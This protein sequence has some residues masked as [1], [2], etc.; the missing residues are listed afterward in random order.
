MLVLEQVRMLPDQQESLR[1]LSHL[2][3]SQDKWMVRLINNP[4]SATM[5]WWD[6]LYSLDEL[7]Q[8]WKR[9]V[10]AWIDFL[11]S[12]TEEQLY[13]SPVYTGADG[14]MWTSKLKDIALQ[15][16]YHSIHHRA[17]IQSLIRKQGFEPKFVDYIGTVARKIS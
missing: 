12:K 17:Q 10:N 6:P 9:S 15:L 5:S 7:K 11:N 14:G 4:A 2:V 8:E 3:N 16:N 13:E 1:Y